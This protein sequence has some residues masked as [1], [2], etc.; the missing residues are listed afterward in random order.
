MDI[1]FFFHIDDAKSFV[2]D[3]RLTWG[4]GHDS[5]PPREAH[6]L[7]TDATRDLPNQLLLCGAPEALWVIATAGQ[8][9]RAAQSSLW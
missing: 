5:I 8:V 1:I 7:E 4:S 6:Y 2:N 9:L 3:G